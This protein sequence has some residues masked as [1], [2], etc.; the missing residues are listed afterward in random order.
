MPAVLVLM[1]M[2]A[3]VLTLLGDD[4]CGDC[5]CRCGEAAAAGTTGSRCRAE[6]CVAGA[7]DESVSREER[8]ATDFTLLELT[9]GSGAG[10]ARFGA[11]FNFSGSEAAVTKEGRPPEMAALAPGGAAAVEGALAARG[12]CGAAEC[13]A[14]AVVGAGVAGGRAGAGCGV[15]GVV[16]VGVA[17]SCGRMRAEA[18]VGGCCVPAGGHEVTSAVGALV[19][20]TAAAV[21]PVR[22]RGSLGFVGDEVVMQGETAAV[23]LGDD[24]SA[25]GA[26]AK[27]GVP[28]LGVEPGVGEAVAAAA[29]DV[30]GVD[31]P[32]ES[33]SRGDWR[34]QG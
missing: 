20:T 4:G 15:V 19:A 16:G 28:R 31:G 18:A 23:R 8:A 12:C 11:D 22:C 7:S 2:V 10:A 27:V 3:A 9:G 21:Q 32:L 30:L 17:T 25:A 29:L 26:R 5:G 34:L 6:P 24:A 33:P 1:L 14:S 13:L